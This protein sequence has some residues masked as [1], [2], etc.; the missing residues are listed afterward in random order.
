MNKASIIVI[1]FACSSAVGSSDME[2]SRTAPA[3]LSSRCW[4]PAVF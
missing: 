1:A 2:S 4:R 3:T